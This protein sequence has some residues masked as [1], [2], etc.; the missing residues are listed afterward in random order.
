MISPTI[1]LK[2]LLL[3]SAL[4]VVLIGIIIQQTTPNDEDQIACIIE[5]NQVVLNHYSGDVLRFSQAFSGNKVTT[6]Q[7]GKLK[8]AIRNYSAVN[9]HDH[10][11]EN[12]WGDQTVSIVGNM[13]EILFFGTVSKSCVNALV[14]AT[15]TNFTISEKAE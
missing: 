10:G 1:N 13:S 15:Q 6:W 9:I 14:D 5:P 12:Q 2:P 11:P 7:K 3:I 4:L 8:P